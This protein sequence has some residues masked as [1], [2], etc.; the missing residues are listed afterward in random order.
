V[1]T[2]APEAVVSPT[3]VVGGRSRPLVHYG[4]LIAAVGALV[5][6]AYLS[7]SVS[8]H[9]VIGLVFVALVALHLVQ[10]RRTIGRL[11]AHAARVRR[12]VEKGVRQI[13]SDAILAFLTLNVAISGIVDWLRTGMPVS[14]PFPPPIN[15]WHKASG[16]V[17]VVYLG[18]HVWHRRKRLRRSN[19][20]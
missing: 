12:V 8:I 2:T 20:R 4:L 11:V 9:A 3:R 10:R 16:V 18:V 7:V 19:I 5:A 14:F 1:R 13:G 6:L 15:T 17:L